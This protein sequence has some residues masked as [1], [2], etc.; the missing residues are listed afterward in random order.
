MQVSRVLDYHIH[1]LSSK[2]IS[3]IVTLTDTQISGPEQFELQVVVVVHE[4][5]GIQ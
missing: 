4:I 3:L 1:L 2:Q 5:I